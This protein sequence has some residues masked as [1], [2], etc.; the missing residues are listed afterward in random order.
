[1]VTGALARSGLPLRHRGSVADENPDPRWVA[2]GRSLFEACDAG[3]IAALIGQR[4]TGKT[5]LASLA[6][7]RLILRASEDAAVSRDVGTPV[8]YTTALDL[9][10]TIRDAMRQPGGSELAAMKRYNAPGLLIIDEIQERGETPWEDRV[11]VE[12]VDKR[13]GACK[14]TVIIANLR[15]DVLADRLGPSI[16]SRMHEGGTVIACEWPGYRGRKVAQ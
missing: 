6:A 9:F 14:P 11:L 4:G 10:L 5:F 16:V 8:V 1:M 3:G 2:A 12:I 13:Y 15:R 7:R